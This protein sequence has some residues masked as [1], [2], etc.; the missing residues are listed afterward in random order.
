MNQELIVI[1]YPNRKLYLLG[2][3]CYVSF[4]DVISLMAKGHTLRVEESETKQDRTKEILG[5]LVL[6]ATKAKV[7]EASEEELELLLKDLIADRE[8]LLKVGAM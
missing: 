6:S 4:S 5:K 8:A 3:G 7:A 2:H 1:L